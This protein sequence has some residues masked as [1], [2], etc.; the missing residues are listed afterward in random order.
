M[1]NRKE[2]LRQ[3]PK[4]DE[5]LAQP[6]AAQAMAQG[7]RAAVTQAARQ[8]AELLRRQILDGG[9][10]DVS[11]EA[12]AALA[13]DIARENS[14]SS[15]RPVINGTGIVL[16]TNLGRA[17]MSHQAALAAME[18]AE[19]YNTLEY[20][21]AKG[22]R[23]SRY[24][25][26]ESLLC[27]LTGAEAAVVVNNNAAAVMLILGTLA[28]DRQVIVSRGELVE[29]GGSFRVPEIMEQ[30]NSTLVEVG[31]T[32]K[33][34]PQDYERAITDQTAAL[35]KVHTSNYKIMGF[36]E[37]VALEQL[38]EIGRRHG[39]PVLYD[40]GSGALADLAD[41]GIG[42]EPTVQWARAAGADIISFSGDKLL[43]GPQAGIIIGKKQY[44]DAM[45]KNPLT[46]AVRIDK[47]TLAALEATLRIYLE[48]EQVSRQ[49]PTY[50]MLSLTMEQLE[51]KGR[52]LLEKLAD[53]PGLHCQLI[54][55][56]GQVGGGS[57]PTQMIPT[58]AVAL[59]H[60]GMTPDQLE[61]GLRLLP[62]PIIGRIS[63]DRFL[64]DLRT[65]QTEYFDLIAQS[66]A[67][68]AKA[69]QGREETP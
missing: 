36:T 12:A 18:V 31:T 21:C 2:L 29:I 47:L 44:I 43:G 13:L 53:I 35:L 68:V 9:S 24:D 1:E 69:Q 33:T 61:T 38:A 56:Q 67:Q 62:T 59:E 20:D 64:L 5:I 41:Y 51:E 32:N 42:G 8:A 11:V 7:K 27:Q 19:N 22:S 34:H 66:I 37:E 14:R 15:L 65:I 52:L 23:G 25:H 40:L 3:I 60:E 48:P 55:E 26:V 30:S 46:R 28:K 4:I 58:R 39:L 63:K 17:V 16:H 10:P 57:V 6:Q 45:K 54:E 49:I 50:R